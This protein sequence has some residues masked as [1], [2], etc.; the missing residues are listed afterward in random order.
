MEHHG[1]RRLEVPSNQ[2]W[3]G[4]CQPFEVPYLAILL[5][6]GASAKTTMRCLVVWCLWCDV[7][8]G[9]PDAMGNQH[10]T[11][12]QDLIVV[13]LMSL[14]RLRVLFGH[15]SVGCLTGCRMVGMRSIQLVGM[16]SI[17]IATQMKM[18]VGRSFRIPCSL[19][20]LNVRK[21]KV[22]SQHVCKSVWIC[23][24]WLSHIFQCI[25]AAGLSK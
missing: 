17:V 15:S 10:C 24:I 12:L 9:A 22:L 3:L 14:T 1:A 6:F 21:E 18:A 13:I 25:V 19:N 20:A 4:E 7:M 11:S 5:I 16:S 23:Q 2:H 8:D